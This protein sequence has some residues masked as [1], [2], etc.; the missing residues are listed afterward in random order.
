MLSRLQP[1]IVVKRLSQC[2]CLPCLCVQLC[3]QLSLP[4]RIKEEVLKQ[5]LEK[6][7]VMQKQQPWFTDGQK[8]ELAEVHSWI[9]TQTVPLQIS[10]QVSSGKGAAAHPCPGQPRHFQPGPSYTAGSQVR[11]LELVFFSWH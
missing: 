10:T 8:K 2:Q 4:C 1:E 3:S 7:A 11:H 5:D 9:R 6:L